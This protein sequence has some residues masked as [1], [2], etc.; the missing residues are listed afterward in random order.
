MKELTKLQQLILNELGVD[1]NE[2]FYILGLFKEI[3]D[4]WKYISEHPYRISK[5]FTLEYLDT[6]GKWDN[7]TLSLSLLDLI[8]RPQYYKIIKKPYIE[9]LTDKEKEFLRYFKFNSLAIINQGDVLRIECNNSINY[10]VLNQ[11]NLKFDNLIEYKIYT[12]E[13]LDL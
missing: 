11:L 8:A 2:E 1:I 12:Y 6:D 4:A 3:E 13:E 5:Y 10:L 9:L 7:Y